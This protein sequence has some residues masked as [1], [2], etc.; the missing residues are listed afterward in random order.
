MT[1]NRQPITEELMK[2]IEDTIAAERA[3]GYEPSMS[4]DRALDLVAALREARA[5]VYRIRQVHLGDPE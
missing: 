2:G 5:H 3:L 1:T 4:A